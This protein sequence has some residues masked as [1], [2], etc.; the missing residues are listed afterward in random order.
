MDNSLIFGIHPVTAAIRKDPENIL[1]A[2]VY[3]GSENKAGSLAG[4]LNNLGIKVQSVPRKTLD[5]MTDGANHQGILIKVRE[6]RQ[7]GENE[8]YEL[9]E[10]TEN[11]L[12]LILDDVTD[13][14]NLGACL[15]N[16]DGAGATAVVT[17]RDK[18]A[19]ISGTVRKVACGAT[20]SVP[21]FQVTNLARTL[22]KL[23][24]LNVW[25]IGTAGEADKL[26]YDVS[27][28][29]GVALVM[30]A[31]EKGMRR[32]TRENCDEL[33]KLPM[34]GQV[35]SLNVSVAS[36]IFLYEAVRQRQIKK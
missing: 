33:V 5:N 11:P 7:P 9:V 24:E 36:G 16:A 19:G 2:W 34:Y 28:T 35:T 15:R 13:P 31:E 22:K 12:I 32:L 25:I 20:E 18:S 6:L 4:E 14:H 21:F 30:G 8:L 29:G 17:P 1:S 10:N 23:Q 26:V 3:Q 27:L